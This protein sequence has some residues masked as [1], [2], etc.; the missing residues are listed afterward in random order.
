[1]IVDQKDI[2]TGKTDLSSTLMI[3][4]DWSG[5]ISDDRPP[6]YEANMRMLEVRG[7]TRVSFDEWLPTTRLSP[8]EYL[9]EVWGI[10]VNR[11]DVMKEYTD[12]FSLVRKSGIVPVVYPDAREFLKQIHADGRQIMVVSSH[13][14]EHLQQE[15]KEYG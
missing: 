13:P 14:E 8:V 2:S 7:I 9:E 11:D 1:M 3:I 15:A 4:T 10:A 12:Y 5:V 6:V